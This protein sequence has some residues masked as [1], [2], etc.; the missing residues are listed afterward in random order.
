MLIVFVSFTM[1]YYPNLL[2]DKN[3]KLND[4]SFVF[5]TVETNSEPSNASAS[6]S[7]DIVNPTTSSSNTEYEYKTPYLSYFASILI[8]SIAFGIF[9]MMFINQ[10]KTFNKIFHNFASQYD[11]KQN[12]HLEHNANYILLTDN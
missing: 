12:T 2:N 10:N 9:A 1:I 3:I 11:T 4:M 6:T 8:I 5:E 7:N